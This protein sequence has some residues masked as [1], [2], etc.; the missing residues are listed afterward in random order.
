ML[1]ILCAATVAMLIPAMS[2]PSASMRPAEFPLPSAPSATVVQA[3]PPEYWGDPG[4]F[5]ISFGTPA[6]VDAR[7]TGPGLGPRNYIV[8]ACTRDD[9]R[10][11]VMPNPCLYQHEYYAKLLCHEQGHLSRPGLGGWRHDILVR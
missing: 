9:R 1:K 3:A 5:N 7:C 10:H 6:T 11:V 8:L 2:G 4:V